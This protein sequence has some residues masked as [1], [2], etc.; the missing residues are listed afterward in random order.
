MWFESWMTIARTI[1]IGSAAYATLIVVLRLAGKRSLSQLNAFDFVVTVALGSTLSTILLDSKV[2]WSEGAIAFVALAGLQL[3]LALITSHFPWTKDVV[4][5]QPALLL[6][7]GVYDDELLKKNR[8][9]RSDIMQKIRSS[10]S[11]DVSSIGAVVLE[12]DGKLSVISNAKMGDG[13]ALESVRQ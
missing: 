2:T 11:G 5:A 10:G 6:R 9:T 13:S 4:S 7:D 1:L 8:L 3:V 12:P